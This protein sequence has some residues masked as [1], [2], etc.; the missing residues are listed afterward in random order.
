MTFSSSIYRHFDVKLQY[1]AYTLDL[2]LL[3]RFT[4]SINYCKYVDVRCE[5]FKR[6]T[7]V[8]YNNENKNPQNFF[9]LP[10]ANI[11]MFYQSEEIVWLQ[12]E[13]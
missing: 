4:S 12:E 8:I 11:R 9:Y 13:P 7:R 2:L 5:V 10:E 6:F 3:K 1:L